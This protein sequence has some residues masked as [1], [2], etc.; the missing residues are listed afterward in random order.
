MRLAKY[1]PVFVALAFALTARGQGTFV[2]D[3]QSSTNETAVGGT[4]TIQYEMPQQS[5]TPTLSGIDFIRLSLQDGL[6]FNGTG[7]T[8][9]VNLR[10]DSP[11][12]PVIA[13][14][15]PVYMPN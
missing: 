11:T 8:V 6:P 10:A 9:Y 1:P 14:T 2:F 3:Q 13:S 12:G 5:F 15:D 4:W 7:S